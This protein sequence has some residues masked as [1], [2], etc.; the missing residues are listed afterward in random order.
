MIC[1]NCKSPVL[2]GEKCPK[3]GKTLALFLPP[4]SDFD[5]KGELYKQTLELRA[6]HLTPKEFEQY[7]CGEQ[8]KLSDARSKIRE[9]EEPLLEEGFDC[10]ETALQQSQSWV[11]TGNDFD[12]QS[13]LN[14]ATHA[15]L[16]IN[17]SIAEDFE[18]T[19][20]DVR[21]QQNN[22]RLQGYQP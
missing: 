1:I 15:D 20:E 18:R 9:G 19:R 13:A 14:W 21:S 22:L 7:L 16:K 5:K 8:Q 3:C 17:L 4:P 2:A 10:W 6:G 12:L 11:Q